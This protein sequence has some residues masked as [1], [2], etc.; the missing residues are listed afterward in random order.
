MN[1]HEYELESINIW[2]EV[3]SQISNKIWGNQLA[4]NYFKYFEIFLIIFFHW[5]F[6]FTSRKNPMINECVYTNHWTYQENKMSNNNEACPFN[7]LIPN[8]SFSKSEA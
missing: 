3:T 4:G 5:N 8:I 2:H 7:F 6:F 1:E